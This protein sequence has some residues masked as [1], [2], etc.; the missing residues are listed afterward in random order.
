MILGKNQK[1]YPLF[2]ITTTATTLATITTMETNPIVTRT[3]VLLY[4]KW[5]LAL[6][7]GVHTFGLG[8]G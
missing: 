5:H 4:L 1:Y 6:G 7:A 3:A 8:A 2:L